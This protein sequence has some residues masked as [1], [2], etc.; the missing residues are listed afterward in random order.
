MT[1]LEAGMRTGRRA[2]RSS[3]HLGF[4]LLEPADILSIMEAKLPLKQTGPNLHS[5][6]PCGLG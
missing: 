1:K 4:F 2:P 3:I 5:L 6:F